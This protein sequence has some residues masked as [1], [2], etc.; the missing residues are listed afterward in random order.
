MEQ[1]KGKGFVDMFLN[2][3]LIP[4]TSPIDYPMKDIYAI[5]SSEKNFENKSVELIP[6]VKWMKAI[7]SDA[8]RAKEMDKVKNKVRENLREGGSISDNRE[9]INKYNKFAIEYNRTI[10]VKEDKM[11]LMDLSE[12]ARL[13]KEALKKK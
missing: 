8:T 11:K 6:H 4:P 1:G 10:K 12:L 13:R 2:D 9:M 5:F 3:F 7:F